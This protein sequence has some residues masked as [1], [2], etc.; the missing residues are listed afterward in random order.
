MSFYENHR[1]ESVPR[2]S[3]EQGAVWH[4]LGKNTILVKIY[5]DEGIDGIGEAFG[6]G[7][8]QT[9]EAALYEFARW[10]KGKDPTQVMRNWQ[11][12]YRG[13]R[14]PLGT[15]TL[16]ALSAVEVALWD[17]A[18]KA[19]GCLASHGTGILVGLG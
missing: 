17:I 15:A 3:W 18:G 10:L 11:A 16:A 7:K 9:T 6:T 12:I 13:T 14:Y 19:S 1:P 5:T 2:Q 8:A 4:W